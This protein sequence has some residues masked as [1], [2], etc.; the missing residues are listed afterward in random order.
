MDL[1]GSSW[2]SGPRIARTDPSP[3]QGPQHAPPPAPDQQGSPPSK[4]WVSCQ[5][6][7]LGFRQVFRQGAPQER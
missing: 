7:P 5:H 6:W 2:V 4:L 3:T 1:G